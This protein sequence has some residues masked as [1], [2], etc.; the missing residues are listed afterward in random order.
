MVNTIKKGLRSQRKVRVFLESKGYLVYMIHHSR[1]SKD[2]F[3][4]F[5]GF[6]VK[7][8]KVMFFQVKSNKMPSIEPFIDFYKR[9]Q[10]D[11]E[12]F[13]VKDRKDIQEIK[14]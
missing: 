9:F 8:G 7:D 3:G 10:I 1:W 2:I 14:I 12:I 6:A 13:I 11:C 4:L 5:D